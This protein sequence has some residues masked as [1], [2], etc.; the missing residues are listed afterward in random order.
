MV[1]LDEREMKERSAAYVVCSF[2]GW[3]RSSKRSSRWL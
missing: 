1:Q 2:F 3:S